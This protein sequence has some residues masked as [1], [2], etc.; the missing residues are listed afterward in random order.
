MEFERGDARLGVVALVGQG[1]KH[2]VVQRFDNPLIEARSMCFW[3]WLNDNISKEGITADLEAMKQQG[4]G[5]AL[6]Y[7][8]SQSIA[9]GDVRIRFAKIL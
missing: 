1:G 8:I 5:G 9:S 3:A 7:E 4:M 2:A 6:T